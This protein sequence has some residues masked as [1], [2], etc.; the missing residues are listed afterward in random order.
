MGDADFNRLRK[1]GVDTEVLTET[2]A[3]GLP[4]WQHQN[5]KCYLYCGVNGSWILGGS[6]AKEKDFKCA[7]GVIY[8]KR[9]SGG[10]MPEKVGGVWLRLGGDQFQED[11]DIA[12]TIKPQRLYVQTPNGQHRCAGEYVPLADRMANGYPLWEHATVGRCWLYSGSNG[13]WIIG[14]TDAAAKN[15]VCTRGVIYCQAVHHGQMPDKMVG[16]WLRLDGEKFREDSKHDAA[17][18]VSTEPPSLHILSPNGQH[19]CGGEYL[20]ISER[21]RGQPV[22]KQRRSHFRICTG[23]EGH[24][25]VT[26]AE[27]K[28]ETM[29]LTYLTYIGGLL[30][31][32]TLGREEQGVKKQAVGNRLS[33]DR[34][35]L[36][37]KTLKITQLK[38]RVANCKEDAEQ[39]V[40]KCEEVH[41]GQ[42]PDKAR[43]GTS[44]E[45]AEGEA[46]EGADA[47]RIHMVP[48]CRLIVRATAGAR[49]IGKQGASIKAIRAHAGAH[50]ECIVMISCGEESTLRQAVSMV[51]DRVFDRSGLP[52][53]ADRDRER[54]HVLDVIVP[55][56]AGGGI[57]GQG[58]ERIR[59]IIE[60]LGCE[61]QVSREPLAGIA[62]HK[63][64]K[65]LARDR[66]P[67]DAG[68]AE[69]GCS[70][71]GSLLEEL[72]N[73]SKT[74]AAL[75]RLQSTLKE[76]VGTE[77]LT[78]E[79][80]ELR[81]A[82][83]SEEDQLRL[84]ARN[85]AEAAGRGEVPLRVLLGQGEAATVV[86]KLGANVARL[87]DLALV[88]IDDA[89]RICSAAQATLAQR[90]RALRLVLGDLATR[91]A[92]IAREEDSAQDRESGLRQVQVR[93]L[94][95][96]DRWDEL[97][98]QL[99]TE[100]QSFPEVTLDIQ[101]PQVVFGQ[102]A[103]LRSIGL[104]GPE[105]AVA[106]CGWRLHKALEP[107]ELPEP[108]PRSER[109]EEEERPKGK[110]KGKGPA[111]P[112]IEN[113]MAGRTES[114]FPPARPRE[115]MPPTTADTFP[116]AADA[117]RDVLYRADGSMVKDDLIKVSL[118]S[119]I[120]KPAKLN[121]TSP[122][123][124]QNCGEQPASCS[125]ETSCDNGLLHKL[126]RVLLPPMQGWQGFVGR[127][128]ARQKMQQAD[129]EVLKER[130][131]LNGR[132]RA[133]K[134]KPHR[135][136]PS[137]APTLEDVWEE[138]EP[139]Q[140]EEMRLQKELQGLQEYLRSKEAAIAEHSAFL[141]EVLPEPLGKNGRLRQAYTRR[142]LA[143]E[144][145]DVMTFTVH[146]KLVDKLFQEYQ[147]EPPAGYN[148][149]TLGQLT[150]ADR[151]AWKMMS[152]EIQGDLGRN[153]LGRRLADVAL[154]KV[155]AEPAFI[156]LLLPLPGSRSS[157]VK[158]SKD[159]QQ[160]EPEPTGV[161]KRKLMKENQKLKER[162]KEAETK[163]KKQDQLHYEEDKTAAPKKMPIKMPKELWG[164]TPMKQGERICY[165][166]NMTTCK[167]KD[168]KCN[169]GLLTLRTEHEHQSDPW[170]ARA[171]ACRAS[172][173]PRSPAA[174][175]G[176]ANRCRC[177][178]MPLQASPN[179]RTATTTVRRFKGKRRWT[180]V[181]A[182]GASAN[183]GKI[184]CPLTLL[185]TDVPQNKVFILFGEHS[186][187]LIGLE[188]GLA[189]LQEL[190]GG[191]QRSKAT[192][193]D[194]EFLLVLNGNPR[195][196]QKVEEGD[197]CL[198]TNPA[199]VDL[200]RN[201]DEE[202][203]Q[204]RLD[205]GRERIL[206]RCYAG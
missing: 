58:G 196:R 47:V 112:R 182:E 63:R 149:V 203:Q 19:R 109:T 97:A 164:L 99:E 161:G 147:R 84:K 73:S 12:V 145:A 95:P 66:N 81:E 68:I 24:W 5:G 101:E 107:W 92:A 154:E 205:M 144:V 82:L 189:L 83:L 22:W 77:V 150:A 3:Q 55:E 129:L 125:G 1:N 168:G 71:P 176:L 133:D 140:R 20:L 42:M 17:I 204:D 136:H 103:L 57:V 142:G 120:A 126:Q 90:L 75:W 195:S 173:V 138:W 41:G 13:M 172:P 85:D 118:T 110:G 25:I 123:G 174:K 30:R 76:L 124:Q 62:G 78:P 18:M 45:G 159:M 155:I 162:L 194:S 93:L 134:A 72:R 26:N 121:V 64:V 10:L 28:E 31:D 181:A 86:G 135:I 104:S 52:D 65:L 108:P 141:R 49:V 50:A 106:L 88:S 130:R 200:N 59:A 187:E 201:W 184:D 131:L 9:T 32:W 193:K 152:E 115:A 43:G 165:G 46:A 175:A 16:N 178:A 171:S 160:T 33:P 38:M 190:C 139:L 56:R 158:D 197:F 148:Q 61:V 44:A 163:K 183:V 170:Q 180:S 94:F 198:R 40:L 128:E 67:I 15:F 169:K 79:H 70:E 206:L 191:S 199:G 14:G 29:G 117:Y 146:E 53:A 188:T 113:A 35:N 116:R 4:V 7:K 166:F 39:A 60:E 143:L 100:R 153:G 105:E 192:R 27:P 177:Q 202:W 179:R 51:L 2:F 21:F 36:Q 156:T 23:S 132:I 80:F 54:P 6:D 111:G 37:L 69:L 185:R 119:S 87:R 137:Q 8:S 48:P 11:S 127:G 34:S 167:A 102:P 122:H 91:N 157:G 151:R 96:G 114:V 98:P 186:R 74:E 89:E